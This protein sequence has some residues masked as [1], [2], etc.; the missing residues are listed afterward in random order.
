[1]SLK[2]NNTEVTQVFYNG[3]EQ[4]SLKFNGVSYFGK[5]FSLTQNT[6]TGTTISISRKNSPNQHAEIGSITTGNTIYYGDIITI[7]ASAGIGYT[8]PKLY[9]NLG[10]GSGL[11]QRT[12]PYTFTVTN[13]VIYY[14]TAISAWETVWSGSRTLTESGSITIPELVAGGSVQITAN[15]EFMD[16][17]IEDEETVY[18]G[19]YFSGSVN[20][21]LLPATIF[22]Y[23]SFVELTRNGNQIIVTF[24]AGEESAKGFSYINN[25]NGSK[26]E[27]LNMKISVII[28]IHNLG[29]QIVIC[30]NSILSQ[31]FKK[32][33][34][35][36][37]TVLD[38]CTDG[39]EKIIR[40]WQAEHTDVNMTLLYSQ[41]KTPGGARNVGLDNK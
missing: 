25:D 10:D 16:F 3:E 27:R 39:T 28:P 38:C 15:V 18:P 11:L 20:R 26:K 33:E 34:Y 4:N 5:R 30:L 36:V 19:E 31:D 22:G 40:D 13:D 23:V 6:S 21:E 37:L 29:E 7:T 12:S 32:T 14:G 41:S 24:N 2:F 8:A 17:Y 1:M 35:E 9:V